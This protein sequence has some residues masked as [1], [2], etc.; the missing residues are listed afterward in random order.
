M[1]NCNESLIMNENCEET[2]EFLFNKSIL[3]E[4]LK[5]RWINIKEVR[6]LLEN[7]E[8]Y[9]NIGWIKESQRID[10][11]M[12]ENMNYFLMDKRCKD[13]RNDGL[14][15]KKKI[16]KGNEVL[17]EYQTKLYDNKEHIGRIIYFSHADDDSIKMFIMKKRCYDLLNSKYYFIQYLEDGVKHKSSDQTQLKLSLL[18]TKH[19]KP[20]MQSDSKCRKSQKFNI[21]KSQNVCKIVKIAPSEIEY[22]N[23]PSSSTDNI[24]EIF[25]ILSNHINCTSFEPI[26]YLGTSNMSIKG[27]FLTSSVI[28]FTCNYYINLVYSISANSYW[29]IFNQTIPS[30]YSFSI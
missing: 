21:I 17:A 7:V 19:K 1:T 3:D 8:Y 22:S 18:N 4:S 15:W 29:A 20:I 13:W 23:Y 10:S 12:L 26:I 5:F 6:L 2:K 24:K 28:S 14:N 30:F 9:M 25:I 27:T 16:S 11:G